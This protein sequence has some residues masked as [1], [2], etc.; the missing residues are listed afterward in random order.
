MAY[1]DLDSVLP[2]SAGYERHWDSVAHAPYIYNPHLQQ[3]ITY[4]DARAIKEKTEYAL[5][6]GLGGI[7][8]WQLAQDKPSGGL[9]DAIHEAKAAGKRK[10]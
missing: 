6:L 1:K 2:V 7:M 10:R 5:K 8:F 3:F 4:E 9:L